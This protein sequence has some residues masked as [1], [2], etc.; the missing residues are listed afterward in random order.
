MIEN[1]IV[2]SSLVFAAVFFA[3]WLL[4]PALRAS[5]ERPKYSFQQNVQSYDQD[6]D[7]GVRS[8]Q[9]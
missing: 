6:Q 5:I 2:F 1:L 7:R 8:N 3:A 9:P 4:R